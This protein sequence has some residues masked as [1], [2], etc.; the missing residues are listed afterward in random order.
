M[1]N[2]K[3]DQHSSDTKGHL[4]WPGVGEA[5]EQPLAQDNVKATFVLHFKH[6]WGLFNRLWSNRCEGVP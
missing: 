3:I 2:R 1:P 5:A 6:R 4:G